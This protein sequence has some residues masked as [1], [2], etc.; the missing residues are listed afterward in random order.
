MTT[1]EDVLAPVKA[2][3]FAILDKAPWE[4]YAV[5]QAVIKGQIDGTKYKGDC[6]CIKG[7]IAKNA[8]LTIG[9]LGTYDSPLFESTYGIKLGLFSSPL[10]QYIVD[11]RPG[12]TPENDERCKQLLAWLNEYIAEQKAKKAASLDAKVMA[13]LDEVLAAAACELAKGKEVAPELVEV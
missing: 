6:C 5:R 3:L 13:G 2:D 4:A 8:G 12:Q 11:I 7:I 1:E 10:E 9:K